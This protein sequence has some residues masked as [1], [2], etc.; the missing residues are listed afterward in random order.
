MASC[1]LAL[2]RGGAG[3]GGGEGVGQGFWPHTW[4]GHR[5]DTGVQ[6][7][8][9]GI[10][11]GGF[12][13]GLQAAHWLLAAAAMFSLMCMCISGSCCCVQSR[14]WK[15]PCAVGP[16]ASGCCCAHS[17]VLHAHTRAVH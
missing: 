13:P 2:V 8:W 9:L 12:F 11:A 5:V 4:D 1:G 10:E 3:Q 7:W 14:A 6:V 16:C 15:S 17:D